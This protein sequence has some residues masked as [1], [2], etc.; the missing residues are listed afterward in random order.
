M[1]PH[2]PTIPRLRGIVLIALAAIALLAGGLSA[3]PATASSTQLG[4]PVQIEQLPVHLWLPNTARAYRVL[5]RSTGENGKP[6]IVS[7][8]VFVPT[9]KAPKNGWPVVSWGH[10]TVGLADNCANSTN[11]RSARDV[12]YLGAWLAAG[13]AV[14]SSDY[15]GFGTPGTHLYLHGRSEAYGIIDMVRAARKVDSSLSD[16]W[17]AVGQS[18]G[19]QGVLFA[20]ALE[21]DYARELDFR[22]TIATAPPTQFR[23]TIASYSLFGASQPVIANFFLVYPAIEAANPGTF[24]ADDYVTPAGKELMTRGETT[25]CF[26]ALA[27][28]SAGKTNGEYFDVS[29]GEYQRAVDLLIPHAEIPIAKHR[30]P[31]FIAQGTADTVV[32]P[33]AAELTA[34]RLRAKGNDV[35]FKSYP[36][37]D[38]LGLMPAALQD[39]LAFANELVRN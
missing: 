25:D 5:Y 16:T 38:H 32:S 20:G 13:Y 28:A 6:T 11:G 31:L 36:G 9:G 15:E 33:E 17:L 27:V 10:G 21:H 12:N 23:D 2:T 26:T 37:V 3:Q 1:T 30:E 35:T 19:A 22:G 29:L 14:V 24:E 4:K 18:Q 8:A 34:D 39:V 7:G